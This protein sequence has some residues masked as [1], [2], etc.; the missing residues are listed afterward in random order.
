MPID[1]GYALTGGG[2]GNLPKQADPLED[3][4]LTTSA[5]PRSSPNFDIALL[6]CTPIEPSEADTSTHDAESVHTDLFSTPTNAPTTSYQSTISRRSW[7]RR[8]A[9]AGLDNSPLGWDAQTDEDTVTETTYDRDWGHYS[10]PLTVSVAEEEDGEP[11]EAAGV[12][13]PLREANVMGKRVDRDDGKDPWD[14]DMVTEPADESDHQ[15]DHHYP[16][17][18]GPF[19]GGRTSGCVARDNSDRPCQHVEAGEPC[20]CFNAEKLLEL[21][22]QL[23]RFRESIPVMGLVCLCSLLRLWICS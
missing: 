14:Y 19:T 11:Q 4:N 15:H 9:F 3:I 23:K 22:A 18:T 1:D 5:Q 21:H 16:G 6:L 13:T 12:A 7:Y 2:H 10:R 8:L 17:L 20:T